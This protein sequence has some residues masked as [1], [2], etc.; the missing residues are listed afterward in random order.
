MQ[1]LVDPQGVIF[2][3]YDETLDLSCLGIL[4][5]QRASH[6]EPDGLGQWWADLSPITGP[7]LG[8]FAHRSQALK[9]E[10]DWLEVM[11][12]FLEKKGWACL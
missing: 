10:H 6:V 12:P 9:A 11:L 3:L 1:L 7:R 8:P 5:I 4:S 2:C